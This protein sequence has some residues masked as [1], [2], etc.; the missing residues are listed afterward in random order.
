MVQSLCEN[1]FLR[2]FRGAAGGED[3]RSALRSGEDRQVDDRSFATY[4]LGSNSYSHSSFVFID[5]PASFDSFWVWGVPRAHFTVLDTVIFQ[6]SPPGWSS[7]Q[8][9]L[10]L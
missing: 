7:H 3:S 8:Q 9:H 10:T 4:R 2:S 1:P 5:I 6:R